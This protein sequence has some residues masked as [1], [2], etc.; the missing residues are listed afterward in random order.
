M[1]ANRNFKRRV[2]ARAT[3]TGESYATALR[4]F[5]PGTS[6]DEMPATKAMRLAVAQTILREDPRRGDELRESGR[7]I[8]RL[9]QQAHDEGARIVHFPEGATCSPHKLV[10]S[11]DGPEKVG[12]SDWDRFEWDVLQEELVATA[13]LASKLGLW[14]VVGS[15][16]RLT[17][18][19]RPYNSLYVISDRGRVATRYDERLLSNTKVSFMYSPGADPVTFDVDGFRFGCALGIEAHYPEVFSEYERLDVDCVLFSSTGYGKPGGPQAFATEVQ[20]HAATNSYWVSFAVG[21]QQSTVA[22]AGA[23]APGGEWLAR[24]P[25]DGMAAVV[26]VDLDDGSEAVCGALQHARP[27]RRLA[28]SGVYDPH[29]VRDDPRSADRA[30]F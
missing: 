20:G 14:T 3:K 5:R 17:P 22:P 15:V 27:W 23:V 25:A 6:G 18:P 8:R 26:V 1:T 28:R 29:L 11:V 12:P 19:N 24:C 10:M 4:H 16:H 21:A 9:M 13:A 30:G 2:R 7:D